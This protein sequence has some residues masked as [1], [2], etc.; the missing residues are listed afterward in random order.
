MIGISSRRLTRQPIPQ[1]GR[2][3]PA[4]VCYRQQSGSGFGTLDSLTDDK[5]TIINC[6]PS[7][8]S[9]LAGLA[10]ATGTY[11]TT[12]ADVTA[13]FVTNHATATGDSCGD[14]CTVTAPATATVTFVASLFVDAD[15]NPQSDHLF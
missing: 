13:G 2:S 5:A 1:P 10:Y 15:E 3:S 9:P 7:T 14:G 12:A 4:C 6:P 8:P 11:R